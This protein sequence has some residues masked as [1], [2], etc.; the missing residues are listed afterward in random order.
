[1]AS[2]EQA[3]TDMRLMA[4]D[5]GMNDDILSVVKALQLMEELLE[6]NP[7]NAHVR[8][9]YGIMLGNAS[10]DFSKFRM[11]NALSWLTSEYRRILV[12]G[13]SE[14][15]IGYAFMIRNSSIYWA[16]IG[17]SNIMR[18]LLNELESFSVGRDVQVQGELARTYAN[19]IASLGSSRPEAIELFSRLKALFEAYPTDEKIKVAYRV[20]DTNMKKSHSV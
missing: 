18:T 17:E 6:S 20:S 15:D 9:E 16:E 14:L 3:S 12:P 19:A 11:G 2:P 10:L 8:I 1:V 13:I 7:G 5:Y 4:V